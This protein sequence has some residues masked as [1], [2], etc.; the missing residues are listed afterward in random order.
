MKAGYLVLGS[1]LHLDTV[2]VPCDLGQ[3]VGHDG[4]VEHEGV[5]AVLLPDR[6]LLG[7][8]GGRAVNL[9]LGGRVRSCNREHYFRYIEYY[10]D[11]HNFILI[12]YNDTFGEPILCMAFRFNYIGEEDLFKCL[13]SKYP[14]R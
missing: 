7:E 14:L 12:Q 2:V 10:V 8:G 6:G 5:A 1:V 3:G 13:V 9:R 4:A 11:L